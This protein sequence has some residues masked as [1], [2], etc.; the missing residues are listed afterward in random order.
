MESIFES[1]KKNIS[2]KL[3]NPFYGAFIISWLIWN[4][5]VWYITFF[6]DSALL[7]ER[8]SILKID[9]INSLY[10]WNDWWNFVYS[11]CHLLLLP[12]LS[13]YLAVFWFPKMTCFFYEKSLETENFNKITKAKKDKDLLKAMGEKLNVEMDVLGKEKAIKAARS[14]KSQKEIWDDEYMQ[15]Q[16]TSHFLNFNSLKSV[17]YQGERWADDIPI[18]LKAYCDTHGITERDEINERKINLTN[19]GKYFMGKFLES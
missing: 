3:I 1:C 17:Y 13:S 9:Y 2:D 18:D 6:I 14:E 7:V 16:K 10:V 4:W 19:K 8:K 15:F 5:R 12:L 11:I